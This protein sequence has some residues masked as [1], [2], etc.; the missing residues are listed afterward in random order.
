MDFSYFDALKLVGALGFFIYGMKVM[1]EGIQKVAGGNLRN[2][3]SAMTSNR[4]KGI[5]TGFLITGMVQSSSATTVMVVSFVN[6]GLLSL[7]ESI[8]VIMGANIGTTVTA[9]LISVLGFSKFSI[10][11]LSLPIIAVGFPL[12][13]F[14]KAKIKFLG[15]VLIG[16]ALLFLGLTA[17][18]DAVPDLKNNP[19]ALEF[20][21]SFTDHGVFSTIFFVIVGTVM[22][23][24]VQSSSAA[25]ALTL[26][27]LSKELITFDIA[28]AMVLGENIGTTITANI[29]ASIANVHAKRA[30]RAH[31]IFNI[32][33]V[34]WMVTL[35]P[36]FIRFVRWIWVPFEGFVQSI[37][38]G[39]LENVTELQLSLFHTAFNIINVLLLIWFVSFIAKTVIRLVPSKDEEED[40]QFS[41]EYIGGNIANTAEVAIV[42]AKKELSRTGEIIARIPGFIVPLVEEKKSKSRGRLL[43]QVKKY[44]DITDQVE[45]EMGKFLSKISEGSLSEDSADDVAK[46]LSITNDIER[47]GDLFYQISLNIQKKA[48]DSDWFSTDQIAGLKKMIDL[49]EAAFSLMNENLSQENYSDVTLASA[50]RIEQKI[51]LKK[52]ELNTLHFQKVKSHGVIINGSIYTE[53]LSLCEK[54]GDHIIS[55]TENI[56]GEMAET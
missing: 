44:E 42:E 8:S 1:S 9:W 11:S 38:P 39:A 41:L 2:I 23:V 49:L 25:M 32:F 21:A 18:K 55:I 33:G 7:T 3:L 45:S 6:A 15:E 34:I 35:F 46:L 56:T 19:E 43:D 40:S 26:T 16:F 48:E 14:K 50:L 17:L 51:N 52:S 22:T 53:L 27:L 47:I 10:A 20:L 4:G 30:A 28:A 24:V 29:A 13:F 36:I 31:F 12:L 54:V 5:F 37:N